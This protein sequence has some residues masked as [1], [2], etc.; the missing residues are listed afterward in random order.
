MLQVDIKRKNIII[1]TITLM[2]IAV[3]CIVIFR[4]SSEDSGESTGTSDFVIECIIN[5]NPFT[6]TLDSM[7]KEE[8]K[9]NMK[10]PIRKLAHFFIYTVLGIT[11][12]CHISTYK[13]NRYQ[14]IGGSLMIGMLY[15]VSD[16]IHQLFI[17]GR[18]GQLTDV[19]IDTIGVLFGVCIVLSVQDVMRKIRGNG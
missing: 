15:A 1:R 5:I 19:L 4:F 13:I 14:R 3:T 17:P 2:L 12:M 16:E 7:Q 18:S 8:I 9:E 11:I 10:M 6:K